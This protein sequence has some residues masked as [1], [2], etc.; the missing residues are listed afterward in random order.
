MLAIPS[1]IISS[2]VKISDIWMFVNEQ[3][4][5]PG[6]F[7]LLTAAPL[8]TRRRPFILFIHCLSTLYKLGGLLLCLSAL[9]GYIPYRRP[10]TFGSDNSENESTLTP[11]NTISLPEPAGSKL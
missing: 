6:S 8:L 11:E 4:T 2:Q 9:N 7:L 5:A 1:L 10:Y 3:V